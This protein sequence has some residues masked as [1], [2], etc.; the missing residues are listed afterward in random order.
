MTSHTSHT[1]YY[2]VYYLIVKLNLKYFIMTKVKYSTT[3]RLHALVQ[4]VD[5]NVISATKKCLC[6]Y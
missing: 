2:K 1:V 4:E 3:N 6:K 5:Q